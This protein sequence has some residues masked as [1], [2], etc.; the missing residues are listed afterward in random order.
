MRDGC[1]V[2]AMHSLRW[3]DPDQV[4]G[5]ASEWMP[6]QPA[7]ADSP[8][9]FQLSL[10]YIERSSALTDALRIKIYDRRHG[11]EEADE[12]HKNH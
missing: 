2:I 9:R 6:S 4:Q 5:S 7:S 3:H 12:T 8:S 10:D 1:R 11:N